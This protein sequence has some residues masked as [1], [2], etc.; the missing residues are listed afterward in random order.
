MLKNRVNFEFKRSCMKHLDWKLLRFLFLDEKLGFKF[1][2]RKNG[3]R[4]N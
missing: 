2:M 4:Y 3:S 1:F